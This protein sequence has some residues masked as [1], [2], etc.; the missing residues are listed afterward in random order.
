MC[1]TTLLA[2]KEAYKHQALQTK[3]V[4]CAAISSCWNSCL[5]AI[6]SDVRNLMVKFLLFPSH[7][8]LHCY[9]N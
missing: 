9:T 8:L 5:G 1:W 3:C 6:G 2:L 4:Y 7:S